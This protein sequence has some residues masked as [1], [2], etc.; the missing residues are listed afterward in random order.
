MSTLKVRARVSASKQRY[1]L[2][3]QYEALDHVASGLRKFPSYVGMSLFFDERER[4]GFK[5]CG[6]VE[7]ED[8]HMHRKHIVDGD[9]W[10]ADEETAK[11]CGVPFDGTFGGDEIHAAELAASAAPVA[12][13][14]PEPAPEL[15]PIVAEHDEP[16]PPAA[17]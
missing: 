17:A 3:P 14:E 4:A 11:A 13:K 8:S 9:L 12:P 15:A 5:P 6:V 1:A 7:I 10:A 16:T 2:V